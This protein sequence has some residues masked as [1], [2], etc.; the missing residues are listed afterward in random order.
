ML[1]VTGCLTEG[2]SHCEACTT[3]ICVLVRFSSEAE[4]DAFKGAL[5]QRYPTAS[6]TRYLQLHSAWI[7]VTASSTVTLHYWRGHTTIWLSGDAAEM[8]YNS[9][10]FTLLRQQACAAVTAAQSTGAMALRA[11]TRVL[12]C[13]PQLI[14]LQPD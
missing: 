12:H 3:A 8:W 2:Q 1:H 13:T 5:V 10:D 14:S 11:N 4:L 6:W 9:D 7:K